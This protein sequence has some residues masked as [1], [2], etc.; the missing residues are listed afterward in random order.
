M[1]MPLWLENAWVGR[2]EARRPDGFSPADAERLLTAF[3]AAPVPL[4]RPL[5]VVSGWRA[6]ALLPA[7]IIANLS[8]LFVS[9]PGR[10]GFVPHSFPTQTDFDAIACRMIERVQQLWPCDR[11]DRTVEVDAVAVSMGGLVCRNAASERMMHGRRRLRIRRL[12]TI[13]TPHRGAWLAERIAVD[14]AARAMKPG[15]AFLA[16][17][18]RELASA[19][20][21][22]VCYARLYDEFVGATRSAPHG[23]DPIWLSGPRV[24]SHLTIAQDRRILADVAARLRGEAEPPLSRWIDTGP[25]PR[26]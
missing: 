4:A 3:R 5:V 24:L 18:D 8:P 14:R 12:F 7:N 11:P 6:L 17:L 15:S 9:E 2:G 26:D 19:D 25:P 16:R 21:E 23:R 10:T 13:G 20:Y 1:L 22:M